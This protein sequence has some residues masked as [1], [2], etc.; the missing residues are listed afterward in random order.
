[1]TR[2]TCAVLM[3]ALEIT[4]GKLPKRPQRNIIRAGRMSLGQY[5]TVLRS[6]QLVMQ[7]HQGIDRGQIAAE[8]PNAA[9]PVQ[10]QQ[11]PARGIER[12]LRQSG[13]RKRSVP[14]AVPP[15]GTG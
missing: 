11:T 1:M 14:Y 2:E 10:P 9:L 12:G 8:M 4:V 6:D 15:V 13:D 5:E 3:E 7:Q